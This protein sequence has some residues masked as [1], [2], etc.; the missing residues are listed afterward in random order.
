M[1]IAL[2]FYPAYVRA[3]TEAC[4]PDRI[5]H[6]GKLQGALVQRF[7]GTAPARL[8]S[9]SSYEQRSGRRLTQLEQTWKNPQRRLRVFFCRTKE[10]V[11]D[12]K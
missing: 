2:W 10:N 7:A 1:L 6:C 5:P 9:G 3:N 11:A 8:T 4:R 12:E